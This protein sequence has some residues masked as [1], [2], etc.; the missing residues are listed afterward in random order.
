M[1][2]VVGKCPVCGEQMNVTRLHCRHCD[3]T[4]EGQ[5]SLSRFYQLTAEQQSFAEN[6]IRCEGRITRL[7]EEMGLSYPAVRARL[8]DLIRALGYEVKE[9]TPPVPAAQRQT[10]LKDLAEGKISPDEALKLLQPSE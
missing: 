3:S 5:F 6:F 4:L 2:P 9:E 8:M 7:Q 1:Y 10:V